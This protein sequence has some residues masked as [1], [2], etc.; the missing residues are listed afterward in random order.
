VIAQIPPGGTGTY[1]VGDL[2]PADEACAGSL[3]FGTT[4]PHFDL[5]IPTKGKPIWMIQTDT[6]NVFQ[7]TATKVSH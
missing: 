1:T 6:G 7:G 5:F 2:N 4:G 3:T